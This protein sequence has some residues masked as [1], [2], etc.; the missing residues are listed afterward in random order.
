MEISFNKTK[1]LATIGP[2][3]NT[4]ERLLALVQEGVDAFRLNFSHGAYSEHQKV[5]DFVREINKQYETNVCLVQDLQGPKIRLGDVENGGIEIKEGQRIKLVCDGSITTADR[6]STIYKDLAKDVEPGHSILLDDGKL[7]LVVIST[8]KDMT[9]EAEVI[10]GG[11][12]KPRKGINLPDS[13]VS[14]PSMTEKDVED[15][16][17]GLDNDVEWVAL[18]FVRRVEDIYEIKKIISER[19]KDTRVIAKIEKPE[20]ITNIDEIIEAT[21]AIMVARG[22]LGVEVGMEQVPMI[23]K[24]LV[25]KC[26][27]AGK[28]V[29][30]ATQMMESMIVNP[31]PTRAETNDVANAVIDGADTV[32]LSAETAVGAYPIE[33]IRSMNMTIRSVERNATNIYNKNYKLNASSETFYN[34]SLVANAC[35]LAHDTNARAIIGMTKS[36]YTAFQITKHRPKSDVFIFTENHRLLNILNLVWGI[37]GFYYDKFESTDATIADIKQILVKAGYLEQGDV[38]INTASMPLNEEKRTNMIKLS[39]A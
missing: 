39:I 34:D 25:A 4:Y 20:A 9:V 29:I 7:E 22:D 30:V 15:L 12:V 28:P 17:F 21:D 26:N 2:A 5:I 31:R 38:F 24:M 19:G 23:Q 11:I 6:L 1:V 16:H 37:R 35:H 36:G 8:D 10:Y 33:T 3:S 14:A 32:M 18:S 27:E 13:K